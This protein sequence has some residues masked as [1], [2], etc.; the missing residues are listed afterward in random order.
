MQRCAV[1]CSAG[2]LRLFRAAGAGA[3]HGWKSKCTEHHHQRLARMK[4]QQL[5]PV[6]FTYAR[7]ATMW[8][9]CGR[10]TSA[11][12]RQ[13]ETSG[14]H[15][16]PSCATAV[17][18]AMPSPAGRLVAVYE[19]RQG[20]KVMR[21]S[22]GLCNWACLATMACLGRLLTGCMIPGLVLQGSGCP[23]RDC[24]RWYR[25]H[26]GAAHPVLFRRRLAAQGKLRWLGSVGCSLCTGRQHNP[27][28]ANDAMLAA[29]RTRA[30]SC[31]LARHSMWHRAEPC[32]PCR[33]PRCSGCNGIV[34]AVCPRLL[35][36]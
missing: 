15:R 36:R 12:W 9:T 35:D 24:Q 22:R 7:R 17:G 5:L 25:P 26:A 2:R 4:V 1:L 11:S 21:T 18:C 13:L 20:Y 8:C 6:C 30:C 29:S 10:V 19:G 23:V 32:R 3:A 16:G 27:S 14:S 33:H 34:I 28:V 31:G